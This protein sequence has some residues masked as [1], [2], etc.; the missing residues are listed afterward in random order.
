MKS[1]VTR[2]EKDTILALPVTWIKADEALS[3]RTF[4]EKRLNHEEVY[5][6]RM[7]YFIILDADQ[8]KG[9][10]SEPSVRIRGNLH[11]ATS[12]HVIRATGLTHRVGPGVQ[13]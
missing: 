7:R 8:F 11:M 5:N 9:P 13:K 3:T 6:V 4:V 10:P 1:V 2:K 12:F